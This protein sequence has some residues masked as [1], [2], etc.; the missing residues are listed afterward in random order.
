[1]HR[2]ES[3]RKKI[4]NERSKKV[5]NV[6]EYHEQNQILKSICTA[7]CSGFKKYSKI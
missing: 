1:M 6:L 5:R 3:N 4:Q 7:K 2:E